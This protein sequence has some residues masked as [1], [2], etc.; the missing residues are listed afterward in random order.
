MKTPEDEAF[1]EIE[2]AQQRRAEVRA[3]DDDDTQCYK[4]PWQS[5]TAAEYRDIL[6]QVEPG[7]GYL[8]FYDLVEKK[9]RGKNT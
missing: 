8:V 4:K 6:K 1:E 3:N 2:K 5:L 7:W 9:L